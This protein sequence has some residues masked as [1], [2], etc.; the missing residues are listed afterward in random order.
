MEIVHET[1]AFERD[2]AASP[3]RLF[4]AYADPR[5]RQAWSA[6]SSD[7]VVSIDHCD[8][9]TGGSET[10]RCGPPGNLTWA[11]R[12]HYHLVEDE[13]LILFTEELREAE[14]LLTV[15]LITFEIL[16]GEAGGSRLKLTDQITSFVGEEGV[17][18]HRDGYGKIL[19]NLAGHLAG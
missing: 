14:E 16:E 5:Q 9:R 8:L 17:G 19:E 13:R 11:M 3:A 2:F 12:L 18:G 6:F 4:A 15:A 1:L 10:A 7:M